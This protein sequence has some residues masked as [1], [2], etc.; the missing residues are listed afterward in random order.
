[1]DKPKYPKVE[2]FDPVK[3]ELR[4]RNWVVALFVASLVFMF[5]GVMAFIT[6]EASA[7]MKHRDRCAAMGQAPATLWP[8][9][10]ICVPVEGK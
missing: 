4:L 1:M 10:W 5:I 8:S 7:E 9:A 3:S 2:F 6:S